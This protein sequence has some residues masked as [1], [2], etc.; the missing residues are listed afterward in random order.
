[1]GRTYWEMER[2]RLATSGSVREV[3]EFLLCSSRRTSSVCLKPFFFKYANTAFSISESSMPSQW[4]W[5]WTC[6]GGGPVG[7]AAPAASVAVAVA[8]EFEVGRING[9]DEARSRRR[10]L[11]KRA[12]VGF[13]AFLS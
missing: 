4:W 6:G 3:E 2:L 13:W 1:M 5:W 10:G 11:K 8:V 12:L 9:S 7:A